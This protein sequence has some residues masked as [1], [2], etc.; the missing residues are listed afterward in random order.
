MV[1][2]EELSWARSTWTFEETI[3]LGFSE[4]DATYHVTSRSI[5]PITVRGLRRFGFPVVAVAA[6][7]LYRTRIDIRLAESDHDIRHQLF[8]HETY[9]SATIKDVKKKETSV[10][11]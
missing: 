8:Q 7:P 6:G 1:Q 4:R 11:K 10:Q 5:I 3:G 2:T 9:D